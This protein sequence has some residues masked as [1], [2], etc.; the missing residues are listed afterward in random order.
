MNFKLIT[1]LFLALMCLDTLEAQQMSFGRA[2][3]RSSVNANIKIEVGVNR[4]ELSPNS[5]GTEMI[6]GGIGWGANVLYYKEGNRYFVEGGVGYRNLNFLISENLSETQKF[7]AKASSIGIPVLV[8]TNF[9]GNNYNVTPLLKGGI[10]VDYTLGLKNERT[11][12]LDLSDLE[13]LDITY[14]LNAGVSLSGIEIL[15]TYNEDINKYIKSIEDKNRYI[16]MK[17]AFYINN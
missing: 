11:D 3:N 15:I 12:I 2:I 7:S 6:N 8:G 9:I 1:T 5:I 16:G 4:S 14:E 13:N 10:R 17:L